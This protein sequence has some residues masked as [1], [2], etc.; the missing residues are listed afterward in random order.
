M[1]DFFNTIR[2]IFAIGE[3]SPSTN[4]RRLTTGNFL[5]SKSPTLLSYL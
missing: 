5:L 3:N 1:L 4:N 2:K